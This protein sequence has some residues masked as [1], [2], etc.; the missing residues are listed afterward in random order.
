MHRPRGNVQSVA[1]ADLNGDGQLDLAVVGFTSNPPL[2]VDEARS[3]PR[4]GDPDG[5]RTLLDRYAREIPRRQLAREAAFLRAKVDA[6]PT[7]DPGPTNP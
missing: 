2:R 4:G 6:A 5:T 3:A 7:I 1:T